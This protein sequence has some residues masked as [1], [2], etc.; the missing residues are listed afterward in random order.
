MEGRFDRMDRTAHLNPQHPSAPSPSLIPPHT[1]L[2]R[3]SPGLHPENKCLTVGV[4]RVSFVSMKNSL[5]IRE[6]PPELNKAAKIASVKQ[7]V[8]LRQFVIDAV[9]TALAGRE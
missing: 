9:K 7:G 8:T 2:G 3:P 4:S 6:F 5:N 1:G